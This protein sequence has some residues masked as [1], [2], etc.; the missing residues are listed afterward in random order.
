M[1]A[2]RKFDETAEIIFH[3]K[4]EQAVPE[5]EKNLK[6]LPQRDV[7]KESDIPIIPQ[8][9]WL[10]ARDS[11]ILNQYFGSILLG[12]M[13]I[14]IAVREFLQGW[15][16]RYVKDKP[17]ISAT[18]WLLEELDFRKAISL[19]E[20]LE[21][22]GQKSDE[23]YGKLHKCYDIRNK[24]SH[25]R[26]TAI[27]GKL[28]DEVVEV[29]DEQGKT[30]KTHTIKEDEMLTAAGAQMN[31]HDDALTMISL[32]EEAFDVI[33]RKSGYWYGKPGQP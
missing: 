17:M 28:A 29:R 21:V 5:F 20:M 26:L 2:D 7:I 12:G 11:Y 10:N 13:A 8:I 19:C 9:F 27:L 1:T 4:L 33:F 25:A 14:E 31:A 22:F 24:Y 6:E 30:V 3:R 18:S 16:E 23:I 32:I 15:F